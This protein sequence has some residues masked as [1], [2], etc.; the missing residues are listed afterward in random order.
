VGEAGAAWFQ[1][2]AEAYDRF[3]GRYGPALADATITRVGMESGWRALDV[4]CGP[5]PLTSALADA[6][7]AERVTAV[8][9]SAPFVRACSER[10][11]G[12]DVRVAS[13][14]ELPFEDGTFDATLSQLVLN[15]LPNPAA[16]LGEMSRVTR[17]GGVIAATVWDYAGEMTMLRA[18]WDAA[19]EL[20]PDTAGP[21]DE[22]ERMPYCRPDQLQQLWQE[23]GLTGIETD[24]LTVIATYEDFED[25]WAPFTTGVGPAGAYA[26]SVSEA[27]REALKEAY[28]GHLGSPEGAF[29]LTARAWIAYGRVSDRGR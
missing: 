8:D 5:G 23:S 25:L 27:D 17:S 20:D 3:V 1:K 24:A 19:K 11:P 14:E 2:P 7:G 21:L 22:G 12:A 18:F 4:G 16:G 28:R 13:A 6:L 26:S 10:V 29:E 15:F 9:P